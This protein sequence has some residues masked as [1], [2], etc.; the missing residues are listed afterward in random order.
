MPRPV[1][2][3]GRAAGSGVA[4]GELVKDTCGVIAPEQNKAHI[5]VEDHLTSS[6]PAK[7]L[8]LKVR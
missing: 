6:E 1:A 7:M 8:K 3:S 5:S 4:M 2:K